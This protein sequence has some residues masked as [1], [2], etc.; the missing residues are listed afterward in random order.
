AIIFSI[1][2]AEG[3]N[4]G[5]AE[6]EVKGTENTE[7]TKTAAHYEIKNDTTDSVTVQCIL[8][9]YDERGRLVSVKTEIAAINPDDTF[10]TALKTDYNPDYT[11]KA[12]IWDSNF[13]PLCGAVT[14]DGSNDGFRIDLTISE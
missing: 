6:I 9:V 8:A 12:F 4:A 3:A 11:T 10:E 2:D 14:W 5:L 7:I 13:V 1:S